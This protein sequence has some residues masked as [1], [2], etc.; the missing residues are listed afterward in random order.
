[1][2]KAKVGRPQYKP[3]EKDRGMVKAMVGVGVPSEDVA[4]VLGIARSTLWVHFKEELDT[5]QTYANAKVAECLFRKAVGGNVTAQIFWCK[6]RMGWSEKDQLDVNVKVSLL[7]SLREA[8]ERREKRI[9]QTDG[10]L[11][12]ETSG[13]C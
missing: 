9:G 7:D 5:A 13:V 1:M 8:N 11:L 6:T 2:S 3:T 10:L 12:A 4:K